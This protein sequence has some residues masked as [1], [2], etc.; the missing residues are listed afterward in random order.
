MADRELHASNLDAEL[1]R[2][3]ADPAPFS[4]LNEG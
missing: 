4:V 1:S 3:G 2:L